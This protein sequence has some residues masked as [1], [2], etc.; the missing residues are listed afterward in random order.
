MITSSVYVIAERAGGWED[1]GGLRAMKALENELTSDAL[2]DKV[3]TIFTA[4][5]ID[6]VEQ[7]TQAMMVPEMAVELSPLLETFVKK[8]CL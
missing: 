8:S 6:S 4:S 2:V 7:W 3:T 5:E 1:E